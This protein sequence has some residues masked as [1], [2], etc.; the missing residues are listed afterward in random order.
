MYADGTYYEGEWQFDQRHGYGG[1]IDIDKDISIGKFLNDVADGK[2]KAWFTNGSFYE[3]NMKGYWMEGQG[4][5]S[6]YNGDIYEGSL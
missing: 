2:F 4:K 5:M 6:F 1:E 3:G